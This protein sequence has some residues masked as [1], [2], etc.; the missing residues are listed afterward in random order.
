[1]NDYHWIKIVTWNYINY[2]VSNNYF[3]IMVLDMSQLL[4]FIRNTWYH[5]TVCNELLRKKTTQKI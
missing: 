5:I 1:M 4:V 2:I 3:E